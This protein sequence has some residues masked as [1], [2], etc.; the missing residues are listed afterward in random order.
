M[1][2]TGRQLSTLTF[3]AVDSLAVDVGS[4]G[5]V[6]D[7]IDL[8]D[9]SEITLTFGGSDISGTPR[10]KFRVSTDN[11]NWTDADA[12]AIAPGASLAG[13]DVSDY[14]I[15]AIEVSVVDSSGLPFPVTLSGSPWLT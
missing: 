12:T 1:I 10:L 13:I 15:G 11:V 4:T 2:L 3:R 7:L 8:A 6:V 5:N 9:I 14:T